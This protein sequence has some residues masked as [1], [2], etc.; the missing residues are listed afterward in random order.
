[1]KGKDESVKKSTNFLLKGEEM[2]PESS[3]GH[4]EEWS[5]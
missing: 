2:C 1:M 3:G 5:V 4:L